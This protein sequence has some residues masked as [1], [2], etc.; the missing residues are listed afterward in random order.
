[1]KTGA[2]AYIIDKTSINDEFRRL[3]EAGFQYCQLCIWNPE[4]YTADIAEETN[5]VKETFK[6]TIST[7]WA[8]WSGPKVWNFHDGPPTIGLVPEKFRIQR[9]KELHQASLFA[10]SIAVRQIATHVGFL[11]EDPNTPIYPAL[12]KDLR[13]LCEF[14]KANGQNF[15]FE[16]GQET[17]ITLLRTIEDI[18]MSN[19]GINFDTANFLLYGKAN[20]L[21]A[22]KVLR[23]YILDIHCKDG[24]YPTNGTTLGKEAPLGKGAASIDDIILFLSDTEYDGTF[25]VE[26]EH[27]NQNKDDIITAKLLLE[28]IHCSYN[29]T[30]I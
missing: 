18:G 17:P 29:G 20:P 7:L 8:G 30:P 11:P 25:I 2:I 5:K 6:I 12:I 16:T 21:D 24:L 10:K 15:L 1:M 14:L 4:L 9:I 22:A 27:G 3:K 13:L 19:V 26:R 28:N 23:K